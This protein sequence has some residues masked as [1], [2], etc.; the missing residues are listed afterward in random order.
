MAGVEWV[1]NL[2]GFMLC[3]NMNFGF[4][5]ISGF[6][7]PL[8]WASLLDSIDGFDQQVVIFWLIASERG[9]RTVLYIDSGPGRAGNEVFPFVL[10]TISI[11]CVSLSLR[12]FLRLTRLRALRIR[13]SSLAKL[14]HIEHGAS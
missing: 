11:Q 9:G 12:A 10:F 2:H 8:L 3:G 4:C 7:I 6:L 13:E 1:A 14:R 5:F